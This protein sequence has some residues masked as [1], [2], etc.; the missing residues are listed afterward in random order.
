[1]STFIK[2]LYDD[3]DDDDDDDDDD[4]SLHADDVA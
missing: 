1:L 4:I 2:E 3:N